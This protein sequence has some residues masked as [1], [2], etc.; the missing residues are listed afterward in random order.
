MQRKRIRAIVVGA[1]VVVAG[2]LAAQGHS[3]SNT[4]PPRRLGDYQCRIALTDLL[5]S[6]RVPE[7]G[8]IYAYSGMFRLQS[9]ETLFGKNTFYTG[10]LKVYDDQEPTSELIKAELLMWRSGELLQ[11][12]VA[13]GRK[14]WA[15]DAK[16]N[17]YSVSNYDGE[18]SQARSPKYR[19]DFLSLF[20][21]PT[22][23]LSLNLVAFGEQL[24]LNGFASVKDW[25]GG[26]PFEGQDDVD[27]Q[28]ALGNHV[29]RRIWQAVPGNGRYA[30]FNCE[31]Y[32]RGATW[33]L[34]SLEIHREDLVGRDVKTTHTLITVEKDSSGVSVTFQRGATDFFYR[35][36]NGAKVLANS[37]VIKF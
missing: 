24:G 5:R 1:A 27:P 30:Q 18:V 17:E 10:T 15:H 31:S 8:N 19:K 35:P 28:D 20:K 4:V 16:R 21:A 23:G 3:Q 34:V 9:T 36:P 2:L 7:A 6:V 22:Q 25:I 12:I 26:L 33:A 32:D 11:R 14:V 13:D 37:R 29:L